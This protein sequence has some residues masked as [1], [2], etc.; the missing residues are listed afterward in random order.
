MGGVIYIA[1]S[2]MNKKIRYE[3]PC[4]C[5]LYRKPH[6]EI[7][8]SITRSGL[9]YFVLHGKQYRCHRQCKDTTA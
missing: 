6:D 9:L 4:A 7:I 3:N 2:V 8:G 1:R 5:C